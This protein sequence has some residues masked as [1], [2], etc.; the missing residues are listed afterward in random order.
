MAKTKFASVDDYIAAQP[1]PVQ[2]ALAR[3]RA[4]IRKGVPGAEESISYQ[5]PAYKLDGAAVI[6]FAGWKRHYSVY[7]ATA[8]LVAAFKGELESYELSKGTIRFP[9]DEPV[10]SSLITRLAK[11]RAREVA[12][13]E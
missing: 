7:P 10:P 2:T 8:K 3:V 5:M 11:F 13:R 6:Y 1:K 9:L 4:A 12:A